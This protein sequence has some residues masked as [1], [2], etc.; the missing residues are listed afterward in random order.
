MAALGH[1][2]LTVGKPKTAYAREG[3]AFYA[4]RLKP[5]GGCSLIHLKPLKTGKG[6][7]PAEIKQKEAGGVLGRLEDRDQVWALEPAGRAWGSEDWAK[8]LEDARLAA[9][10]RL[11]LVI[12]GAEG[13]GERVLERADSLVSLGPMVMAHELAAL[14]ALEQLYRAHNI[15]AGTPYHR[16]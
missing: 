16:A 3:L 9:N 14:V 1:A 13:L 11:V 6:V 2:L 10:R 15:L 5:F 4:K 12:G 8:H 7:S